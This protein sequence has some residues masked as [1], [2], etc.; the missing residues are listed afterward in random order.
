MNKRTLV[1][2]ATTN[3][4]RYAW[5]A[6]DRLQQAN[7]EVAC[8][9]IKNGACAGVPIQHSFEG[10]GEV[11][12]VTLYVGP[13]NQDPYIDQIIDLQPQRVIFNPGT[14]SKTNMDKIESAGIEVERACTLVMLSAGTY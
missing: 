5:L 6:T 3:P 10:L 9:G 1:V 11:H 8:V 7:Y 13:Q 14:E 4:A 12:T 2:G